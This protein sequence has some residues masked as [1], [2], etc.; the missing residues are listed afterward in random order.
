MRL[1]FLG[2]TQLGPKLGKLL[3]MVL[4]AA[5]P[6]VSEAELHKA[7]KGTEPEAIVT[8]TK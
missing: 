5:L 7:L 3:L 6:E 4:P 1:P 8:M 2:L